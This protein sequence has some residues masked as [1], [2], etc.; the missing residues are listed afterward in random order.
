MVPREPLPN[1]FSTL[2]IKFKHRVETRRA[3]QQFLSIGRELDSVSLIEPRI[4]TQSRFTGVHVDQ[5]NGLGCGQCHFIS[6]GVYAIGLDGGKSPFR[7]GQAPIEPVI[8][9]ENAATIPRTYGRA[10][11]LPNTPGSASH[12]VYLIVVFFQLQCRLYGEYDLLVLREA[13]I[14]LICDSGSDE[15]T[16]FASAVRCDDR[17]TF[18]VLA[19]F[20]K[21]D[22]SPRIIGRH[23]FRFS[24]S[25]RDFRPA[26]KRV[27]YRFLCGPCLSRL[28]VVSP[29]RYF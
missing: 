13:G 4:V 12:K 15:K 16:G 25:V 8:T 27:R 5:L 28:S 11:S 3:D 23:A 20:I 6:A 29:V 26:R 7:F 2:G 17:T 10:F 21:F 1:D 9:R 22:G 19:G 14:V 24:T 18:L